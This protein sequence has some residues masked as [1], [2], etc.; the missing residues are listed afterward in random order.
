MI[1]RPPRSTLFPYTTLFRSLRALQGDT[2]QHRSRLNTLGRTRRTMAGREAFVQDAVQRVLTTSERLGGIIVFIVDMYVVMF[3]GV[4]HVFRQKIVVNERFGRFRGKL[5]HHAGRRVGIHVGI[6]TS[7]V[8]GLNVHNIQEHVTRLSLAG[9]GTLVA[10]L[11]ISLGHILSRTAHQLYF[12]SVLNS[13]DGHLR[14]SFIYNVAGDFLYQILVLTLLGVQ[15]RLT[16]G[17]HDLL[18]VEANYATIT[19]YY[20]LYHFLCSC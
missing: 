8:V 20:G 6:L 4:A 5:H 18:F 19:L 16:D 11:D 1:R 9:N 13:L 12:H 17:G 7:D 14:L 2:S 3:H 10:I 15:H